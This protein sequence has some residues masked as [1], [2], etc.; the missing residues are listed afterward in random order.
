[1]E[2]MEGVMGN[3][4]LREVLRMGQREEAYGEGAKLGL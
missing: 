1:M 2:S 4:A 3:G